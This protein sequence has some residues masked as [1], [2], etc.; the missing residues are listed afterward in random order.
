[1]STE[2]KERL[3]KASA[4]PKLSEI[5]IPSVAELV[6]GA[7]HNLESIVG[8]G[9][10][11]NIV[12]EMIDGF[13]DWEKDH[14]I[15]LLENADV[16]SS[17]W[18]LALAVEALSGYAYF[19]VVHTAWRNEEYHEKAW[20]KRQIDLLGSAVKHN[21]DCQFHLKDLLDRALD[22]FELDEGKELPPTALARLAGVSEGAVRNLLSGKTKKYEP[23][24][25]CI[26]NEDAISY[27]NE[28]CAH[29][30]PTIWASDADLEELQQSGDDSAEEVL[31]PIFVPV[32]ADGSVFH[33][34]LTRSG[35]FTVGPKDNERKVSNFEEA[36]SILQAAPAPNWRRPNKNGHW[37]NVLGVRWERKT[38]G[39]LERLRKTG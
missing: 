6:L 11:E 27:L 10:S 31:E 12:L 28:R 39:E 14:D 24:R 5:Y 15:V 23:V 29:F 13:E 38:S 3:D 4:L 26:R 37:G 9:Y 7:L 25:G 20:L 22:R 19:G 33:P 16:V 35:K 32:S 2:Y 17:R 36:L 30:L 18:P 21:P 34:G 8:G 1:M